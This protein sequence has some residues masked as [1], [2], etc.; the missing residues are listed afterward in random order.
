MNSQGCQSDFDRTISRVLI[1]EMAFNKFGDLLL[2]SRSDN[3]FAEHNAMALV[4]EREPRK[5]VTAD[6]DR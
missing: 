5:T 4:A 6:Q 2:V 1:V 3:S